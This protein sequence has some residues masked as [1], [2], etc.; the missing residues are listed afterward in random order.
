MVRVALVPVVLLAIG[1]GLVA[2]EPAGP[3]SGCPSLSGTYAVTWELDGGMPNAAC[4]GPRPASW[5][6]N[7]RSETMVTCVINGV[8]LGGSYYDTYDVALSGSDVRLSYRMRALAIPLSGLP[9]SGIRLQGTLTTRTTSTMGDT[10][11][12]VEKF[13]AER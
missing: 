8:T 4:P 9:D 6:V 2:C 12:S 1:V 11:E 3:C 5:E 10:C 13:N 7:Q